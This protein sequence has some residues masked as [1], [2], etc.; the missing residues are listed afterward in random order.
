[1][2]FRTREE[3]S[4]SSEA[5]GRQNAIILAPEGRRLALANR[6][7]PSLPHIISSKKIIMKLGIYQHYSGKYYQVLGISR[8]SE[9]L[10][11]FVVYQALYGDFGLWVR[12]IHMFSEKIQYES[13]EVS[14]F[15]FVSEGVAKAPEVRV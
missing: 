13:R 10:E 4:G 8:H 15:S 2:R 6:V 5:R 9:T 3:G 1:M 7:N 12:P 11:D 14:R